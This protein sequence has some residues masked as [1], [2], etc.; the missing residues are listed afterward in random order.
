[1]RRHAL[2]EFLRK[3]P[4]LHGNSAPAKNCFHTTGPAPAIF[5]EFTGAGPVMRKQFF[6]GAEFP[7]NG[8]LFRKSSS[9][10]CLRILFVPS[11]AGKSISKINAGTFQLHSLTGRQRKTGRAW[12][13]QA[14]F[15]SPFTLARRVIIAL[16]Q[17]PENLLMKRLQTGL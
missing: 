8:G 15:L 7:C 6:S 3:S 13:E 2:E 14:G 9:K 16:L 10:A 1:M 12:E 4:P 11:H 5:A 17:T